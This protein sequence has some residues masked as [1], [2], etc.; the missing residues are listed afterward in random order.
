MFI[1]SL[2]FAMADFDAQQAQAQAQAH[3]FQFDQDQA[4]IAF[5]E[6]V[7][8]SATYLYINDVFIFRSAKVAV[9][10]DREYLVRYFVFGFSR[11]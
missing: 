5:L 9:I 8:Y 3:Q 1:A 11:L 7:K 4:R 10:S 6:H 2:F